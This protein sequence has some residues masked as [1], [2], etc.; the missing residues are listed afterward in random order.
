M[1]GVIYKKVFIGIFLF[2]FLKKIFFKKIT[3]LLA[4]K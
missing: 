4:Q 3:N 2:L 1:G